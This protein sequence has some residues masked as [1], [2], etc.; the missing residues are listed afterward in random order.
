VEVDCET[1]F[2]ARNE[3]FQAF[4]KSLAMHVAAAV[5][6]AEHLTREQVPAETLERERRIARES[7]SVKGKPP[8]V[9]EKIVEGKIASFL[10]GCVLLEQAWI[11]DEAKTVQQIVQ[12]L[13]AKL[14]ENVIV[15]RFA[16]FEVGS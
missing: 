1:D 15:R 10:K 5:P 2:V 12:E 7:D 9:V 14:G 8:Q 16:R 13:I 6:R 11:H 3:L 4:L